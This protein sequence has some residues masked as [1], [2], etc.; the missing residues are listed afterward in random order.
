MAAIEEGSLE[1][2]MEAMQGSASN[3]AAPLLGGV[4]FV[5]GGGMTEVAT[6]D[7]RLR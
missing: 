7:E 4:W 3:S 2:R 6:A 5:R 1:A